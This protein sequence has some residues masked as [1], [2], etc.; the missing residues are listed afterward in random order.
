MI[1]CIRT[2]HIKMGN[3]FCSNTNIPFCSVSRFFIFKAVDTS[4]KKSCTYRVGNNVVRIFVK[5]TYTLT[6]L[7][8]GINHLKIKHYYIAGKSEVIYEMFHFKKYLINFFKKSMG[9][10]YPLN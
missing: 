2:V 3:N 6:A 4:V 1:A 8:P 10:S 5:T 7:N 9:E